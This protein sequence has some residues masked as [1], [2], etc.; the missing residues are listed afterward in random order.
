MRSEQASWRQRWGPTQFLC[1]QAPLHFHG[2]HGPKSISKYG[3]RQY[4]YW[5]CSIS[6]AAENSCQCCH[7]MKIIEELSMKIICKNIKVSLNEL[8][9]NCA[10]IT[11]TDHQYRIYL[12]LAR[13]SMDNTSWWWWQVPHSDRG[14]Y[15]CYARLL[16]FETARAK[17]R[18]ESR[19]TS[20]ELM[21]SGAIMG[22]QKTITHYHYYADASWKEPSKNLLRPHTCAM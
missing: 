6:C 19:G 7:N 5:N 2:T 18:E 3:N 1:N 20:Q 21:W 17:R 14:N 9:A 13:K 11:I 15:G 4:G 22:R 10:P 12:N 16:K 8:S